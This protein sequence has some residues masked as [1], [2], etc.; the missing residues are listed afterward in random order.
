MT[1]IPSL[2]FSGQQLRDTLT[3]LD[4]AIDGKEATGTAAAAVAAHLAAADPH[5]AY[6]TQTEAGAL[7]A[8]LASAHD[9]VTLG[10]TV[11]DVVGLTGQQLTADDPGAGADRLL[12]WDHSAGRL[13]HLTLGA[14]LAIND[15]TIDA[16]GGG[17]GGGYPLFTAPTGFSVTGSGTA[18]ITLAFATGYSLPTTANQANWDT[19]YSER[20]RWDGGATGLNAAT[21]RASLGL[22]SAAQSATTDYRHRSTEH[23]R[24]RSL[25]AGCAG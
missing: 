5:P 4:G 14:N 13:R 12:F 18:S 19:A 20:L 6:L 10:A 11:A 23:H 3:A 9:P 17:G 8:P 22:G 7:Y 25:P 16:T 1:T 24:I 15:T 21:A 2:P